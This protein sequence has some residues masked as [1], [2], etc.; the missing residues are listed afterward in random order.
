MDE[1][2]GDSQHKGKGAMRAG[3]ADGAGQQVILG[4]R[5]ILGITPELAPWASRAR[6]L[7]EM[8]HSKPIQPNV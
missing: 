2:G 5:Q 6:A 8:T 3:N 7:Q 4:A 1:K